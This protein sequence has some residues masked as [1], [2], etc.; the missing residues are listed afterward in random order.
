MQ[1]RIKEHPQ[2][3]EDYSDYDKVEGFHVECTPLS[4]VAITTMKLILIGK[5]T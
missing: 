5:Q 3:Q 2:Y 4:I 1:T